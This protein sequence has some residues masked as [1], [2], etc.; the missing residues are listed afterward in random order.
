LALAEAGQLAVAIQ[1]YRFVLR[2]D[3]SHARAWN[4]LGVLYWR[5]ERLDAARQ[6]FA[7]ALIAAPGLAEAQRNLFEL[8]SRA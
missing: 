3:P 7:R 6:A 2:P 8:D 5:S 4:N 1:R